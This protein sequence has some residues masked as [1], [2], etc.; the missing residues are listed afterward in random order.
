MLQKPIS[1]WSGSY[2]YA[3]SRVETPRS[4]EDL[5][6]IVLSSPK[7][8]VIGTRHTYNGIADSEVAVSL[9]NLDQSPRLE[10]ETN[11]VSIG[12][13]ATYVDLAIFLSDT[14]FAIRQLASHPDM[15][16]AGAIATATHGSGDRNGNLATAVRALEFMIAD[17]SVV[18]FK[19]GEPEFTAS[20]VHL[21][22]LGIITRVWLEVVDAFDVAQTVYEDLSWASFVDNLDLITK[23][24]YSVSVFSAWG[25]NAGLLWLKDVR[26]TAEMPDE[27]FGARRARQKRHPIVGSDVDAATEQLGVAA[28]WNETLPHFKAG[29]I[30]SSGDEIQSEYHIPRQYGADAIRALIAVKQ[31]FAHLVYATE[32]R[33]VAEDDLLL[34][35]QY[36]TPTLSVHFTWQRKHEEVVAALMQIEKVLAPFNVRPHWGKFFVVSNVQKRYPEFHKF[37]HLREKLDPENKFSNRWLEQVVFNEA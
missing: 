14:G 26:P 18:V 5:R 1:N 34:S 28:N 35:P 7:L 12:G 8:K 33:T 6:K 25:D 36:Q 11:Q 37:R 30:G 9:D 32:F 10:I 22:A 17:G 2:D 27:L 15:T 3:F 16:I 29:R 19:Q 24:A 13:S 23:A 31:K 20:V 21:G 4:I